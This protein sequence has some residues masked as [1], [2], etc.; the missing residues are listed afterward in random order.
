MRRFY[1]AIAAAVVIAAVVGSFFSYVYYFNSTTTASV[2]QNLA[3]IAP[4]QASSNNN[5]STAHFTLIESDSGPYEGI[6]GSGHHD[7][8]KPWPIMNVKLGQTVVIQVSDLC[9]D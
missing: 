6:N 9:I 2:C 7:L 8:L 4:G 3:N 5:S 1:L